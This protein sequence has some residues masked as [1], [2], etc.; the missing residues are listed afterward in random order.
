MVVWAPLK[1]TV[2]ETTD[3][4]AWRW[5]WPVAYVSP[6]VGLVAF[7][8][9][10]ATGWMP[11]LFVP[12]LYAFVGIPILDAV[13]GLA[14]SN[15][16]E[17]AMADIAQSS[18]YERYL[19]FFIGIQLWTYILAVWFVANHTDAWWQQALIALNL[20]LLGGLAYGPAHEIGHQQGWRKTWAQL[21]M[22]QIFY[23]H[24]FIQHNRGHHR[25]VATPEDPGSAR[26]GESFWAFFPR[27]VIGG[28]RASWQ[29]EARRLRARG[30]SVWHPS[31]ANLKVWFLSFVL[32]A[33]AVAYAG[34]SIVGFIVAQ[35]V[36]GFLFLE[37]VMY[38]THYGLLR[39][40]LPSGRYEQI[41]YGHSWSSTWMFSN[42]FLFNLQRHGDHHVHPTRLFPSL[43]HRDDAPHLPTG[44]VMMATLALVPPLFFRAMNPRVAELY[45][46]D[47]TQANLTPKLRRQLGPAPIAEAEPIRAASQ[48]AESVVTQAAEPVVTQAVEPAAQQGTEG[49]VGRSEA[50]TA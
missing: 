3:H 34:W 23:G 19:R 20:G 32:Y 45:D 17:S 4:D 24:F 12:L 43:I 41:H 37:A 30:K 21:S 46:G 48:S 26:Y 35:A 10:L 44:M 49:S 14:R 18:L 29:L 39:R 11:L 27:A 36:I 15:R 47:L 38:F 28:F 25:W 16:S 2:E 9:Y 1:V 6:Y 42:M 5:L 40:K 50:E 7:G 13:M 31:N 22:A 8:A 33:G